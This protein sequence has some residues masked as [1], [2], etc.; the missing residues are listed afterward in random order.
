MCGRIGGIIYPYINYLSKIQI[1]IVNDQLPLIIFGIMSLVATVFVIP[2]PETNN[3]P[4]P[5]T[6][7]D[8]ENYSE[9][10]KNSHINSKESN[11]L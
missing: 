8:V 9:F 7:D 3:N 5:I 2:L 10:C 1:P 11:P 4:L 6:I